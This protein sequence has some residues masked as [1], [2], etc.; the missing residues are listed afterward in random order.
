MGMKEPVSLVFGFN[1]YG[2]VYHQRVAVAVV[3]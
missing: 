2:I 3:V 1:N